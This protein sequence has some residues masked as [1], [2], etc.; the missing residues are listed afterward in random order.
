MI[1]LG[2]K[3]KLYSKIYKARNKKKGK[4]NNFSFRRKIC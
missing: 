4:I 2:E 1:K 3:L